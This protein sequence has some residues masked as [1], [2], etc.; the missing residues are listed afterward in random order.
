MAKSKSFVLK[1]KCEK[2][3]SQHINLWISIK[4]TIS[5]KSVK[6]VNFYKIK[7]TML[8]ELSTGKHRILS[9]TKDHALAKKG[10]PIYFAFVLVT[11]KET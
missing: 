8:S 10:N 4:S 7:S 1:A 9:I 2:Y 3:L 6:S 11:E 5:T